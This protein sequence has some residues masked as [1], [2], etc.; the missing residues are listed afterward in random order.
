MTAAP[1]ED[2]KPANVMMTREGNV[3]CP[4]DSAAAPECARLVQFSR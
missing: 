3:R 1:Q 4:E 2:L